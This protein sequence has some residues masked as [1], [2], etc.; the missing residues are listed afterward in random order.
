MKL[1]IFSI[2]DEKALSYNTPQYLA[3]QGEAI[4]MLQTT[5]DNKESMISKYPKDFSLYCLG[6][7]DNNTGRFEGYNEPKLIMRASELLV[8]GDLDEGVNITP[9]K[10]ENVAEKAVNA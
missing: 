6:L 1:K 3:H 10:P 4:R 5:L 8:V 7:Y 2:Y 9:E